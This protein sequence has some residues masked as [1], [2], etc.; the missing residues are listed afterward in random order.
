ME[1][2]KQMADASGNRVQYLFEAEHARSGNVFVVYQELSGKFAMLLEEKSIF[3]QKYG[4]T[5]E[6]KNTGNEREVRETES[7]KAVPPVIKK[8]NVQKEPEINQDLL[9]FLDAETCKEKIEILLAIQ[10][11]VDRRILSNIAAALDITLTDGT[12]EEDMDAVLSYLR[13]R[14][15]FETRH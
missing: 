2:G 1:Y 11:R 12:L 14:A 15:R 8:E 7:G 9:R 6:E 5:I 10:E 3:Y 4:I 13:A